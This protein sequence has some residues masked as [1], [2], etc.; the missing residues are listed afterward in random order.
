MSRS[1]RSSSSVSLF[2]FLA[3]LVCA[4]GAL[5]FLLVITTRRIRSE[6]V[7]KATREQQVVEVVEASDSAQL[8]QRREDEADAAASLPEPAAAAIPIAEDESDAP[9]PP[10]P[11]D[12][13]LPLRAR[14]AALEDE[15]A[16]VRRR[17]DA[18]LHEL[19]ETRQQSA[20]LQQAVVQ[21]DGRL[22]AVR[23]EAADLET[24]HAAGR[25]ELERLLHEQRELRRRLREL[26]QTP[27]TGESR[28]ALVPFDGVSG[29]DRR[30]IYIEFTGE[31]VRFL[32]E[33]VLLTKEDLE[34]YTLG[35]NP[36]LAGTQTLVDYWRHV[37]RTSGDTREPYVLFIVRPSGVGYYPARQ[38]L[39]RLDV[40]SGYELLE[41]DRQLA[42]PPAD[43][44]AV[45][46]LRAAIAAVLR[47]RQEL[48][49]R[50]QQSRYGRPSIGI[51]TRLGGAPADGGNGGISR[52]NPAAADGG[53]TT[54]DDDG[55][56]FGRV[57]GGARET[58]FGVDRSASALFG[59]TAGG[60]RTGVAGSGSPTSTGSHREADLPPSPDDD[61]TTP[62]PLLRGGQGGVAGDEQLSNRSRTSSASPGSTFSAR[63]E[64]KAAGNALAPHPPQPPLSKGGSFGAGSQR[65]LANDVNTGDSRHA[66]DESVP[67]VAHGSDHEHKTA[68]AAAATAGTTSPSRP[69]S[70]GRTLDGGRRG[71]TGDAAEGA[72]TADPNSQPGGSG[73]AGQSGGGHRSPSSG[74]GASGSASEAVPGEAEPAFPDF[75]PRFAERQTATL[76]SRTRRWGQALPGASIGFEREIDVAISADQLAI[77][78]EPPI[79]LGEDTTRAEV[80]RAALESVERTVNGWGLPPRPFYWVPSL[81]FRIAPGGNHHYLWLEDPL[82]RSSLPSKA[83]YEFG[84]S[85]VSTLNPQPST[86]R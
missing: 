75:S 5:I 14:L 72:L 60:D 62:P 39:A 13:D 17:I 85:Q 6:A 33:G 12:P 45:E 16:A 19:S 22:S 71:G 44:A 31:G 77:S 36:L 34:D 41:E 8:T 70:K 37:G 35:Y 68:D 73:A 49:T 81:R 10:E 54:G 11:P 82:K 48:L 55:Y 18:R 1:A 50:L 80:V 38:L 24:R 51:A 32:P 15:L 65:G 67:F 25:T 2:P 76:R 40:Q 64:P 83:I 28:Y 42:L 74:G 53:V 7:L 30:P 84:N 9:P 79:P 21:T 66:L 59:P 69:L 29:T 61:P 20:D 56:R 86:L 4:M 78:G 23:A 26:E 43:P 3:V 58:P 46:A 47:E 57:F 27:Q 63:G 52:S